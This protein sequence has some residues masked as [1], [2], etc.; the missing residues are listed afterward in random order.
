MLK[1]HRNKV[2]II[3]IWPSWEPPLSHPFFMSGENDNATLTILRWWY[4]D[5]TGSDSDGE[6]NLHWVVHHLEG[7]WGYADTAQGHPICFHPGLPLLSWLLLLKH[8]IYPY[9]FNVN[10]HHSMKNCNIY[11]KSNRPTMIAI[12]LNYHYTMSEMKPLMNRT[13]RIYY[14]IKHE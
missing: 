5:N 1:T 14:I 9:L 12:D 6:N 2:H 3:K 10:L 8:S 13:S 7:L 11:R 4:H